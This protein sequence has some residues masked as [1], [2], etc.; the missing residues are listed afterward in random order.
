MNLYSVLKGGHPGQF[1]FFQRVSFL[2]EGKVMHHFVLFHQS[3]T[4]GP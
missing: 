4:V 1:P 2:G 3:G